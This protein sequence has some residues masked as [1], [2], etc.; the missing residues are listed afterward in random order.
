MVSLSR[1][2]VQYFDVVG[3]S[4]ASSKQPIFVTS[5][6][7]NVAGVQY[8]VN[9][10][11]IMVKS[12][13]T[14]AA[15]MKIFLSTTGTGS[16]LPQNGLSYE[17]TAPESQFSSFVISREIPIVYTLTATT[18]GTTGVYASCNTAIKT[19]MNISGYIETNI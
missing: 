19:K 7:S 11:D 6:S 14:T 8:R 10:I 3:S 9:I 18:A 4:I 2:E 5:T 15:D 12:P 1:N 17:Y 16:T 13:V